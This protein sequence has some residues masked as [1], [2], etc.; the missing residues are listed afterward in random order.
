M[1]RGGVDRGDQLCGYYSC[2]SK[3]RKF[4]KYIYHFLFDVSIAY[5]YILWKYFSSASN[6][7]LKE[8]RLRLAEQLIWDYCSHKHR[9]QSGPSVL[10]RSSTS[11]WRWTVTSFPSSERAEDA[12]TVNNTTSAQIHPDSLKNAVCGC[13]TVVSLEMTAFSCST[14]QA[15][16]TNETASVVLAMSGICWCV[17]ACACQCILSLILCLHW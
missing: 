4:Y 14:K 5:S 17:S 15:S 9:G 8:F 11:L 6:L 7:I 2:R 1:F 13:V 10:S 12:L 3:I 16:V